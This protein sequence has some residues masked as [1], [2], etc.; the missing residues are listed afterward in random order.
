V[1]SVELNVEY[2]RFNSVSR[3]E[4]LGLDSSSVTKDAA[5]TTPCGPFGPFEASE[6]SVAFEELGRTAAAYVTIATTAS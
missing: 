2:A 5:D 3:V 6:A 4:G 1:R